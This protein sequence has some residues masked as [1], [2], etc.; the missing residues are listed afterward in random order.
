MAARVL[1]RT[2]L[3]IP[4]GFALLLG[5]ALWLLW[6]GHKAR[7]VAGSAATQKR[8]ASEAGK[9]AWA[10]TAPPREQPGPGRRSPPP[11]EHV[12]LSAEPPPADPSQDDRSPTLARVLQLAQ[13]TPQQEAR[14]R[15]L[16][17]EHE[18]GRRELLSQSSPSA[19][20]VEYINRDQLRLLDGK[21]E[22]ALVSEV[23]EPLQRE[24]V[25]E[26]IGR[27]YPSQRP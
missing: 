8:E 10:R 5:F 20:S 3:L 16:W 18:N 21:F 13:P 12:A 26:A 24:R 22:M 9:P 23:L 14:I 11:A 15:V 27:R 25:L 19:A 4:S 17:K 1:S 7:D 2:R 6:G